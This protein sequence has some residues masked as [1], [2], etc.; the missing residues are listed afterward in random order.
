MDLPLEFLI[1]LQELREAVAKPMQIT[2]GYRCAEHPIEKKKS[3]PGYHNRGAVDIA[4]HGEF[5]SH[6]QQMLKQ[7]QLSLKQLAS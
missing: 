4:A 7:A 6:D 1:A 2:S 3:S 5:P